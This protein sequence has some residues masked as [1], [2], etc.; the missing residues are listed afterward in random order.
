MTYM[1]VILIFFSFLFT[2]G[3]FAVREKSLDQ[4]QHVIVPLSIQS[5]ILARAAETTE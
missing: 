4:F 2:F 5:K 1:S 3:S